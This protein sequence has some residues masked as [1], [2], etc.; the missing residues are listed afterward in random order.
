MELVNLI[1]VNKVSL[2]IL[3]MNALNVHHIIQ[4]LKTRPNASSQNACPVSI[5]A[6]RVFVN[7]VSHLEMCLRMENTASLKNVIM[8]LRSSL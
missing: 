8:I 7:T 4:V 2:K 1:N 6:L 3:T 5:S